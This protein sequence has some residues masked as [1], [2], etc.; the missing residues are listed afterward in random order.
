MVGINKEI[1]VRARDDCLAS[2]ERKK[3]EEEIVDVVKVLSIPLWLTLLVQA[4]GVWAMP[5]CYQAR[6]GGLS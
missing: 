3:K 4:G 2:W 5:G 6:A 1:L